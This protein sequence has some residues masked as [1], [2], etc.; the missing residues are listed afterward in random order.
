MNSLYYECH[1]TVE[2]VFGERLEEF[3]R[4][5][6]KENFHVAKLLMQKRAEDTP[7][8]S[9][10]DSF[11]TGHSQDYSDIYIRMINLCHRLQ[12]ADFQVWRYKIEDCVLDSR[13]SDT[14]GLLDTRALA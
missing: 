13:K 9:A 12:D 8:R 4:I 7:E 14:L 3:S 10:K 2:P 5:C 11:C 6:E 1:V